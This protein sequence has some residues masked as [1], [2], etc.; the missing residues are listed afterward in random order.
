MINRRSVIF[1]SLFDAIIEAKVR[2]S[3]K[4]ENIHILQLEI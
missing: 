1:Y 4:H 3:S 2:I